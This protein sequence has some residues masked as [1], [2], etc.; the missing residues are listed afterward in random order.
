MLIFNRFYCYQSVSLGT[1]SGSC[2]SWCY[3]SQKIKIIDQQY[4][5]V[6]PVTDKYVTICLNLM[7]LLIFIIIII[8]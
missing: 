1:A 3:A 7:L 4:L 2:E 8:L 5:I 6:I